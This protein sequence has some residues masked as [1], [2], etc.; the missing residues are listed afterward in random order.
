M[1]ASFSPSVRR[2]CPCSAKSVSGP[3]SESSPSCPPAPLLRLH[4]RDVPRPVSIGDGNPGRTIL[5][6]GRRLRHSRGAQRAGAS[7]NPRAQRVSGVPGCAGFDSDTNGRHTLRSPEFQASIRT[8]KMGQW[9]FGRREGVL[10]GRWPGSAC[11]SV[12]E[13]PA[14]S[15]RQSLLPAPGSP[16]D[17]SV[18]TDPRKTLNRRYQRHP[19][20]ADWC[21]KV[22]K[23]AGILSLARR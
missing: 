22:A 12:R 14:P 7:R 19:P 8:M 13:F 21:A 15:P 4:R 17:P 20:Q 1:I 6:P 2:W 16:V 10:A 5:Q 11:R 18:S 23:W 3:S 9:A